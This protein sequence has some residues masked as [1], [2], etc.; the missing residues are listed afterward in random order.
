M[1]GVTISYGKAAVPVYRAY[2]TPLTGIAAV[3]ESS[4]TGRDNTLMAIEVAVDVFGDTFL[5]AYLEGDNSAVVA[6][7]SMKNFILAKGVEYEGATMEGFLA[8]LGRGFLETYPD[9]ESLGLSG[10]E[11]RFD[12]LQ[13]VLY[14]RSHD[15]HGV[16]NLF[17]ARDGQGRPELGTLQSGRVAIELYKVT[18]SSFTRFVRDEYTTLP[19]R[20]DRPLYIHLDLHWQYLSVEDAV[21]HDPSRYIPSE[22]VR[23]VVT[24]VFSEIVSESIQQLVWEMSDRLLER[25]PQMAE[26]SFVAQN[27]TREPVGAREDDARAKVYSDPFPAFGTISLTRRR[28]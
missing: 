26:C 20:V 24:A 28:V 3:P 2:G 9:M 7:D 4:F 6:T 25:F 17:V 19:E 27:R 10:R 18:G 22:Q 16:A 8:L 5:P 11:L 15:D 14:S 13:G 12:L 23:D 1:K 21:S